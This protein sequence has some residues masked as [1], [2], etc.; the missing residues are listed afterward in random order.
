MKD[1]ERV[2]KPSRVRKLLALLAGTAGGVGLYGAAARAG[3]RSWMR[4]KNQQTYD[5]TVREL[6][7]YLENPADI[8]TSGTPAERDALLRQ[9]LSRQ[10]ARD[11]LAENIH[12]IRASEGDILPGKNTVEQAQSLQRMIE[13]MAP[14]TPEQVRAREEIWRK[15]PNMRGQ[16]AFENLAP[17]G[18]INR[19]ANRLRGGFLRLN[20]ELR[21]LIN[22][23]LK[24]LANY[25]ESVAVS[26][27]ILAPMRLAKPSLALSGGAWNA[28]KS[29]MPLKRVEPALHTAMDTA[30]IAPFITSRY[31]A[32]TIDR[33]LP[34]SHTG[35]RWDP[36]WVNRVRNTSTSTAKLFGTNL[37]SSLMRP[38]A[39]WKAM[40]KSGADIRVLLRE[41][42]QATER[43]PTDAQKKKG[44]YRM[45]HL[46]MHGFDI[47]LEN[48]K[49]SIRSGVTRT[50]HRWRRRM[51]AHY[52]YIRRAEGADGDGL[53]VFIGPHP[54]S[55]LVVV[56]DQC[57]PTTKKFDEHKLVFGVRSIDEAVALYY[58]NYQQ[59]WGGL[60]AASATTVENI[61]DWITRGDTSRPFAQQLRSAIK[62]AGFF[63]RLL[64]RETQA[65]V[66]RRLG[67][68][69][70][71]ATLRRL[72]DPNDYE[73][74]PATE[75]RL[76][77]ARRA[78]G[79][80]NIA[81]AREQ[82]IA[83][84]DTDPAAFAKQVAV[85]RAG[86]QQS[87][88]R[89]PAAVGAIVPAR[90]PAALPTRT[91]T[92]V[93]A[94]LQQ[95]PPAPAPVVR[96]VQANS[97]TPVRQSVQAT[98]PN[99][100]SYAQFTPVQSQPRPAARPPVNAGQQP[101]MQIA[102]P[103]PPMGQRIA[104]STPTSRAVAMPNAAASAL[105][106]AG[107]PGMASKRAGAVP[108]YTGV[109]HQQFMP[110]YAR[111]E[112]TKDELADVEA[113]KGQIIPKIFTS[114][115]DRPSVDLASPGWS[116]LGAGSVGALLGA[117]A[118]ANAST[119]GRAIGTAL[120]AAVAAAIAYH[121]RKAKNDSIVEQIRRL[122]RGATRR[123]ILADPLVQRD[124]ELA[125]YRAALAQP[126][127][128]GLVGGYLVARQRGGHTYEL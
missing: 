21:A 40:R 35:P 78:A 71:E 64:G 118:T 23:D 43:N 128:P 6:V 66:E 8:P 49:G 18:L 61:K 34:S 38:I 2:R 55:E 97:A 81:G 115:A 60:M 70:R 109:A 90:P 25:G 32:D 68:P 108:G 1:I 117:G 5:E 30:S 52:G 123:D 73:S 95:G 80:G 113:N 56:V 16:E 94:A 107:A 120:P 119:T 53:D 29:L 83:L 50:G 93:G 44:N 51:T 45:G 62:A 121:A 91:A 22:Q 31:T 82:L 111:R 77:A 112:L 79:Q 125:A 42:A 69:G 105:P 41:A 116:A 4:T 67:A 7:P 122:P 27:P 37:A 86:K 36:Q 104:A 47:S 102:R 110:Q 13:A 20:P 87:V 14:L 28:V 101:A 63:D 96:G 15:Y 84:R 57:D 74:I 89:L 124:R 126:N 98:L 12:H 24:R 46:R 59:G 39:Y 48:P 106:A 72:R 19:A 3:D 17:D 33:V 100:G 75:A 9:R 92:S 10:D 99:G 54:E 65:D 114:L 88:G 76:E 11:Y 127:V 58:S 85:Y 103:S 26:T